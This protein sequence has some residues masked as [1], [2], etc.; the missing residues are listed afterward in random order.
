MYAREAMPER[1]GR[2]DLERLIR[3]H[4]HLLST[5]NVVSLDYGAKTVGGV[6]TDRPALVVGVMEKRPA[7]AIVAPDVPVP[8]TVDLETAAGRV[9]LETD[10]VEEGEINALGLPVGGGTLIRTAGLAAGGSLGANIAYQGTYRLLS[11]A[12]VLTAFDPNFVGKAVDYCDAG[13][14]SCHPLGVTVTGQVAVTSY[15][16]ST[17]PDPVLNTQDLAW[18]DISHQA[19]DPAIKEIGVPAGIR[20][21]QVN[22]GVRVYAGYSE[23]LQIS[24]VLS[25][26]AAHTT[27]GLDSGGHT[28]YSF[29]QNAIKLD[30]SEMTLLPGDS[31]SA[32]VA[33]SDSKVVGLLY[34]GG[35]MYGYACAL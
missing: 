9:T 33:T 1:P 8:A 11:C 35:V 22:E 20:P 24:R 32:V 15:P 28:I 27:R 12:H 26:T 4:V 14:A 16:T 21:P 34:G 18:A 7:N 31:G 23:S 13:W 25:V 3:S 5:P 6:A 17:Q 30:A 29:W 2:T 10:V 19:G